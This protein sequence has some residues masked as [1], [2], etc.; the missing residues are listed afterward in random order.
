MGL[1]LEDSLDGGEAEVEPRGEG[2]T[3]SVSLLTASSVH[4][5]ERA[6]RY[7]HRA[8]FCLSLSHFLR[9]PC[10][11]LTNAP[12]NLSHSFRASSKVFF[13]DKH[14]HGISRPSWLICVGPLLCCL[15]KMEQRAGRECAVMG[16]SIEL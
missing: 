15:E 5:S 16:T 7:P 13:H 9:C 6:R 4:R 10:P 8:P 14:G 11:A 12:T 2:V 1:D 3:C